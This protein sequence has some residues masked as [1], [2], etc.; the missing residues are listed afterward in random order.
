MKNLFCLLLICFVSTSLS[1][2]IE[3]KVPMGSKTHT[4]TGNQLFNGNSDESTYY[5]IKDKVLHYYYVNKYEGKVIQFIHTTCPTKS[6]DLKSIEYKDY[7]DG[8]KFMYIT[9][10]K[11]AKDVTVTKIQDGDLSGDDNNISTTEDEESLFLIIINTEEMGQ[12]LVS[13]IKKG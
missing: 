9:T 10:K 3:V 4:F 13:K 12:E 1:A 2:Q 5:V 7:D 6:L 11:I 8:G